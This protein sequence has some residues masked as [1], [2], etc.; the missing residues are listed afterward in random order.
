MGTPLYGL[1]RYV[2]SQRVWGTVFALSVVFGMLFRGSYF[3]II[4]DK[5]IN[6][7][8][9][10]QN[11]F[12]IGLNLIRI[13]NNYKTG[14]KQFIDLMVRSLMTRVSNFWSCPKKIREKSQILVFKRVRVLGHRLHTPT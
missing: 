4:I 12:N 3:F 2:Q 5:T 13:Q 10:L 1:M 11:A 9:A 14:L 8:K 6:Q 7:I